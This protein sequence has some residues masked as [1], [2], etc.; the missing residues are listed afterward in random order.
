MKTIILLLFLFP[1]AA[2]AQVSKDMPDSVRKMLVA[3]IIPIRVVY[4]PEVQKELECVKEQQDRIKR[5]WMEHR[6]A[7]RLANEAAKLIEDNDEHNEF[8]AEAEA[9]NIA[10]STAM[11]QDI[12]LPHQLK[13]LDQLTLRLKIE[14]FGLPILRDEP[15]IS[16]LNFPGKTLDHLQEV[17]DQAHE[18]KQATIQAAQMVYIQAIKKAE[19][20][21]NAKI[22]AVLTPQQREALDELLGPPLKTE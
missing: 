10:K 21:C 7:G 5:M 13:R 3:K 20:E 2:L 19:E 14:Q 1:T 9:E 18:E 22:M 16:H 12:L 6:A 11:L 4:K 15:E 8:L 17:T